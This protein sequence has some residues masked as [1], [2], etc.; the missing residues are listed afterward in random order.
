MRHQLLDSD[1]QHFYRCGD[2]QKFRKMAACTSMRRE[3]A[4]G[5]RNQPLCGLTRM[6]SWDRDTGRTVRGSSGECQNTPGTNY[7][8]GVFTL[9][10]VGNQSNAGD[11]RWDGFSD[12]GGI[13]PAGV[14]KL[15]AFRPLLSALGGLLPT[16]LPDSPSV[17]RIASLRRGTSIEKVS[18][19]FAAPGEF[20][21]HIRSIGDG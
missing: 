1:E 9:T 13:L 20:I 14:D 4:Q 10:A 7:A 17:D 12:L 18:A 11:S 21:Q 2:P 3:R 8:E 19:D 5:T 6:P 16:A 15:Q